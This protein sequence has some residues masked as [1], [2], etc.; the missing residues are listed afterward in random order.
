MLLSKILV[1]TLDLDVFIQE[2][3]MNIFTRQGFR[4]KIFVK[5]FSTPIYLEEI[6]NFFKKVHEDVFSWL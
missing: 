1:F 4:T 5:D 3:K 6:F 2:Q